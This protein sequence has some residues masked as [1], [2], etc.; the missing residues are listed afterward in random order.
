MRE[1][2]AFSS[3][4]SDT[5]RSS[6]S[7]GSAAAVTAN[8]AFLALGS[9]TGGSIRI[10]AHF[11][12]VYGHKPSLDVVPMRGHIP[13]PPAPLEPAELAGLQRAGALLG[14]DSEIALVAEHGGRPEESWKRPA[15]VGISPR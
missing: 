14:L 6:T 11:C 8:A 2:S 3:K 7:G 5:R 10:P 1:K 9:D 13:P 15:R 4:A 12:G